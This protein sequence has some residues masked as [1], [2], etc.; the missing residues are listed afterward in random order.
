M[1]RFPN[2][3]LGTLTPIEVELIA[4]IPPEGVSLRR[5]TGHN[6]RDDIPGRFEDEAGCEA[7]RVK[8]LEELHRPIS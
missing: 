5:E 6:S 2:C 3:P 1:E 7:K 8:P 4:D